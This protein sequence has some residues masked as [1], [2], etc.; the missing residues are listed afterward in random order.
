MVT[1]MP[2][3]R[4]RSGSLPASGHRD[5]REVESIL[6]S[7]AST[8]IG[9]TSNDVSTSSDNASIIEGLTNVNLQ[10]KEWKR[11][12]GA[13]RK[14]RRRVRLE[15]EAR[16]L[17]S[18][19]S[20]GTGEGVRFIGPL[21][22]YAYMPSSAPKAQAEGGPKTRTDARARN[23]PGPSKDRAFTGPLMQPSTS[24]SRSQQDPPGPKR[25]RGTP[26]SDKGTQKK[27]KVDSSVTF[28]DV[29]L[30]SHRLAV[31]QESYPVDLMT[32]EDFISLK[33]R[34]T[35]VIL[36]GPESDP[37]PNFIRTRFISGS[38]R[39]ECANEYSKT[40]LYNTIEKIPGLR[41]ATEEELG[42]IAKVWAIVFDPNVEAEVFLKLLK[43]AN[44]ELLVGLWRC[45]YTKREGDKTVFTLLIDKQNSLKKLKELDYRP[46]Y[47]LS[48]VHFR[49]DEE[50]E[51]KKDDAT[52][53][54]AQASTSK[55]AAI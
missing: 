8:I 21:P 6:S 15:A 55:G 45:V 35:E 3:P 26:G 22:R 40:W 42:S 28:K 36:D 47:L 29:L 52:P 5:S 43:R 10:K 48:R 49:V 34:L 51:E 1:A 12:C 41:V 53:A 38:A 46:F 37:A 11:P 9:R 18:A 44:P 30:I 39:F 54:V 14:R 23:N 16:A 24:T 17:A 50:A 13:E 31:V 19:G 2:M 32:E 27:R 25:P 4:P 33:N 7:P 20:S